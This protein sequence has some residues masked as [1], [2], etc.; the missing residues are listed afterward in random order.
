[1]QILNFSKKVLQ[2]L[3]V[4]PDIYKYGGVSNVTVSKIDYNGELFTPDDVVLITGGGSGIGLAMAKRFIEEG[5]TVIITGRDKEKL[6]KSMRDIDSDRFFYTIWDA[7]DVSIISRKFQEIQDI[8]GKQVSIL[9]N[10]AGTYASTHFPH[11][12]SNDWDYVYNT[13]LKSQYFISQYFVKMHLNQNVCI[14]G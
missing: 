4:L 2:T 10:N 14:G 11:T 13:N 6:E 3:R 1:M 7:S 5:A 9:I 8:T 12:T